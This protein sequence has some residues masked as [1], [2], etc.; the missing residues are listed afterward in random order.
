MEKGEWPDS[1]RVDGCP[2]SRRAPARWRDLRRQ[3]TLPPPTR[4][5]TWWQGHLGFSLHRTCATPPVDVLV[6]DEA[7]QLALADA[8]A[9]SNSAKALILLGDPLQ[10]AQVSKAIHPGDSGSSV[11]EH[12]LG[13]HDDP[14]GPGVFF[15]ETRRMHPAVCEFISSQFYENRLSSTRVQRPANRRDRSRTGLAKGHPLRSSTDSPE[16]ADLVK[17]TIIELIGRTWTDRRQL[18]LRSRP[19]TSWWWR[20]TTT[21]YIACVK[22]R[23]LP[24]NEWHRGRNGRQVSRPSG[25]G[26]LLHHDDVDGADMPKA[27]SRCRNEGIGT[28]DKMLAQIAQ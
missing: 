11:L 3:E 27:P 19:G 25:A 6:I 2:R 10:L 7:G 16:E 14:T 9:A 13:E 20:P 23:W 24:A 21:R 5:T 26:C 28:P 1:L 4:S 17:S 22:S 12:I 8:L 15:S 18:P